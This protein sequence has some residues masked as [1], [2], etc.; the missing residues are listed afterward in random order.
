MRYF[1]ASAAILCTLLLLSTQSLIAQTDTFT[2]GEKVEFKPNQFQD[3]WEEGVIVKISPETTPGLRQVVIRHSSPYNPNYFPEEAY[4]VEFVRHLQKTAAVPP[5]KPAGQP[6]EG[7]DR[8]QPA[9]TA[10]AGANGAVMT[11]AEVIGYMRTHGYANG[12]PKHDAGVCKDLIEMIKARGIE[13]R[14]EIGKDDLTPFAENG[15]YNEQ[16]TDVVAASKVNIGAPVDQQWLTGTWIMYVVGGTVDTAPG[17]GWIYRK[18][19]S[20]AKLGFL[21]ISGDGSYTWKVEPTDPP[22]KYVKGHWRAATPPEMVLQGG[23]GIVLRH[24]AEGADWIVFKYM[25]PFNKADR[26]EVEHMQYRGAY[27]R[28]GWRR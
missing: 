13:A 25:D 9:A 18:N 28:M 10:P 24:A 15:C 5:T 27:R 23:A 22:A 21:T 14:F 6:Q 16:A 2:V 7:P 12:R 20:V 8:D 1:F 19:E 11:K 4:S 3:R 26:I 17:D